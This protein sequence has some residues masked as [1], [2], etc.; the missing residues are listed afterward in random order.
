MATE[1]KVPKVVL[2]VGSNPS[3]ASTCDA[4]FHGSTKSSKILTGWC[5]GLPGMKMHINVLDKKTEDNR[6][7]KVGEIKSNLED[8]KEKIRWIKPDAIVALGKTA[9]KA[10]ELI[11]ANFY[12]MPH[13]SGRNRLL[14]DPAYVA[15]K[16][17]GLIDYVSAALN[18]EEQTSTIPV[19]P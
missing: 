2:F 4:A 16:I 15:E 7:L 8:L 13:P 11:E 10:L 18:K 17:K 19:S 5:E 1:T 9:T 12:E 3:N 14:N 6:P